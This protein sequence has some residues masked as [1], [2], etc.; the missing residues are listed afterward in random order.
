MAQVEKPVAKLVKQS[1][2]VNSNSSNAGLKIF[3]AA[4]KSAAF[5]D[6]KKATLANTLKS[7]SLFN[8]T[9]NYRALQKQ[10]VQSDNINFNLPLTQNKSILI[11]LIRNQITSPDFFI[12]TS[13]GQIVK[14]PESVNNHFLGIAEENNNSLAA[15]SF[16]QSGVTGFFSDASGNNIIEPA[17][18]N[19]LQIIY[20]DNDITTKQKLN[21]I[22]DESSLPA[23]TLKNFSTSV[24]Q[25]PQSCKTVKMYIECTYAM[26]LAHNSNIDSVINFVF[27]LFNASSAIFKNDGINIQISE[28]FIWNQ[29]DIYEG[30]TNTPG[31]AYGLQNKLN[32]EYLAGRGINADI[33]HLITPK[34]F[35]GGAATGIGII[36]NCGKANGVLVSAASSSIRPFPAL[37][38][39]SFSVFTFAHETGH[40]LG[41]PHTQSCIWP[42]GAI[43]DCASPEGICQPGPPPVTGGTMMSY[44]YQSP[45]GVNFLNGFGLLP[46][47]LIRDQIERTACISTCEDTSCANL[48]LRGVEVII[49]ASSLKLKWIKEAPKY[50]VGLKPN[51][52]QQW[53]YYEVINADSFA[54]TKTS[55]EVKYDYSI[56]PFCNA[57]NKYGISYFSSIGDTKAIRL[58]FKVPFFGINR[59]S[60]CAGDSVYLAVIP[61]SNFVY[62]W[63]INGIQQ[64]QFNTDSI[65]TT[66][67]GK[68][69]V[70][71]T[72]NGCNYYS[73]T[74]IV[75]R[76]P[77]NP[78]VL[79]RINGLNVFFSRL[80][81]QCSKTN[82]WD[83][84]DGIQASVDTVTHIYARKGIYNVTLKVWDAEGNMEQVQKTLEILDEYVDSLNGSTKYGQDLGVNY[85]SFACR[86]TAL[87]TQD[88]LNKIGNS[89]PPQPSLRYGIGSNNTL[90]SSPQTGTLE[91][92]LLPKQGLIRLYYLGYNTPVQLS[93]TGYVLNTNWVVF[94]EKNTFFLF[95]SKW[96][97]MQVAVDSVVLGNIAK[98]VAG[99]LKLN[100]WN[101]IGISYGDSGIR[102][103]LNGQSFASD[104]HILDSAHALKLG[105]FNFGTHIG[106][107]GYETNGYNYLK[108]FEGA[109]D[110]VR[111]SHRQKDFTFSSMLPWQGKDTVVINK[112]I[113]FG[114]SFEGHNKTGTYFKK[115][116]TADGCDSITTVNLI[117]NN[118]IALNDS[119]VHPLDILKGAIFI[120]NISG[121]LAPYKFSWSNGNT[122][123]NLVNA[124]PDNYTV[125]IKDS[126]GCEK[127][128]MYKLYQLNSNKDYVVLLPNPVMENKLLTLRIG[129]ANNKNYNCIIYDVT[130]RKQW[131]QKIQ[132]NLGVTDFTLNIGLHKGVY[133][134]QLMNSK[135]KRSVKFI[136]N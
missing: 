20:N 52:T 31:L 63:Y 16:N 82:L 19:G 116:I 74:F 33:A 83:F 124:Q 56:S 23:N 68:Y 40:M 11:K 91:F 42:G 100:E 89:L 41:S 72:H 81:N 95:F 122:A 62:R 132:A 44:C 9:S 4:D 8:V 45:Y 80:G 21:C 130:G 103:M 58:K 32:E 93:D 117:V 136:V 125:N 113:C 118:D 22:V 55:C 25:A 7:Y 84:G 61:D 109:L 106:K 133:I 119:V 10:I 115:N 107:I 128:F 102:V 127:Y 75:T 1:F 77:Q 15:F 49:N 101:N 30:I 2:A 98:G 3:K 94:P 134:L 86:N 96:G 108:G 88:T 66:K 114:N 131:E 50:K 121:G 17:D 28:M 71:T 87:F 39:F 99:P 59:Y 65:I 85:S 46:S 123:Q 51:T 24:V 48:Q 64:S 47:A 70:E 60:F 6:T 13:A 29:P 111:F 57:Q 73:D 79:V 105:T 35:S 43:D 126:L 92:K 78:R 90:F 54:I 26:Y 14:T 69:H 104:A 110:M 97:G 12:K 129:T 34:N 37:P 112:Q 120:K 76:I 27:T 36:N 53:Q 5:N 67:I 18:A 135:E 38:A